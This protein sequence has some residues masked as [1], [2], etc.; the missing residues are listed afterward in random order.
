MRGYGIAKI[1]PVYREKC[2]QPD[3]GAD[4]SF[5]NTELPLPLSLGVEGLYYFP[6]LP[7]NRAPNTWLPSRLLH[8]PQKLKRNIKLEVSYVPKYEQF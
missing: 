7:N 1:E 2:T 8:F 3:K 5:T 4:S 6:A